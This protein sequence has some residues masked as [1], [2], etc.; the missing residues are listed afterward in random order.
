MQEFLT[1]LVPV[2]LNMSRRAQVL[3]NAIAWLQEHTAANDHCSD[4]CKVVH[5]WA[6]CHNIRLTE[7]KLPS[8]M[9]W[10][11]HFSLNISAFKMEAFEVNVY[12]FLS[13][14][15]RQD[16]VSAGISVHMMGGSVGKNKYVFFPRICDCY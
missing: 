7:E 11:P 16:L 2:R 14:T 15:A 10:E 12:I 1:F 8:S 9:L 13:A 4:R 6:G 3:E 5:S